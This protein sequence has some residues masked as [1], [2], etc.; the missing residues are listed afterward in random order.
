[1]LAHR[2][3][4]PA[5][6]VERQRVV[7]DPDLDHVVSRGAE[8]LVEGDGDRLA[9]GQVDLLLGAEAAVDHQADADALGRVRAEVVDLRLDQRGE[10][11]GDDRGVELQRR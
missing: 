5:L 10:P 11:H 4:Q 3:G 2:D 7:V 8:G 9:D 1:M 6:V